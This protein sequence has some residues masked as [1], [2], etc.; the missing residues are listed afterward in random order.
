M[1][2]AELFREREEKIP[3]GKYGCMWE[4]NIKTY[5]QYNEEV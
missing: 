2:T 3:L 5:L 4:N 1:N